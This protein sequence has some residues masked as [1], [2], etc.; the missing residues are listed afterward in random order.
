MRCSDRRGWSAGCQRWTS[1]CVA[2]PGSTANAAS[3]PSMCSPSRCSRSASWATHTQCG[4]GRPVASY[5][6]RTQEVAW[7]PGA[8]FSHGTAC[9][10][11]RSARLGYRRVS[12]RLRRLSLPEGATADR[13]VRVARGRDG[14][15]RQGLLGALRIQEVS[16]WAADAYN[17][18]IGGTAAQHQATPATWLAARLPAFFALSK[19]FTDRL[20]A[21]V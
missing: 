4:R 12:T 2:L 19:C 6:S 11:N 5:R 13:R 18:H 16:R 17:V 21:S 9:A 8:L 14:R 15:C 1:P 3:T 10:P 20:A 7:V